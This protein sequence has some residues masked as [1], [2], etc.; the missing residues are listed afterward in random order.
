MKRVLLRGVRGFITLAGC[1]FWLILIVNL[2]ERS[3][4]RTNKFLVYASDAVLP[5]YILHQAVI[6][7]LG[8]YIVRWELPVALKY[9]IIST[10][11]FV[12]MMAI[13]GL[14]VRRIDVLRFLF[15]MRGRKKPGA[16]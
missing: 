13:Y 6:I 3:L 15:G 2:G 11:S 4:N 16:A 12:M 7:C 9:L 10:S 8:F 1:V 14:L 5:F